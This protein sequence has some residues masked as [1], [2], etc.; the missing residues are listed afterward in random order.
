MADGYQTGAPELMAAAQEL[1]QSNADLMNEL[2]MLA[3]SID[4][5]SGQWVGAAKTAFDTLTNSFQRDATTLNNKLNDIAEQVSGSATAYRAQE[6]Q[7]SQALSS[8]NAT[9]DG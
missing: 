2:K 8:I 1:E 7:A 9:L 3:G 5:V 6:E 4:A